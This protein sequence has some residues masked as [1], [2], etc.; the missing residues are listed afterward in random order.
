MGSTVLEAQGAQE[1]NQPQTRP[2]AVSFPNPL[3]LLSEAENLS[4][5]ELGSFDQRI[6][7]AMDL[8]R[9]NIMDRVRDDMNAWRSERNE[10]MDKIAHLED[11]VQVLSTENNTLRSHV[12]PEALG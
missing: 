7:L 8:V 3:A 12:G 5:E 9:D 11:R 2:P 6:E 4:T 10:L 1:T